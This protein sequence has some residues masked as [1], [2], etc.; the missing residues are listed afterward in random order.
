MIPKRRIFAAL[1]RRFGS[2]GSVARFL[3]LSENSVERKVNSGQG[4]D[5]EREILPMEDDLAVFP[6]TVERFRSALQQMNNDPRLS[7]HVETIHGALMSI[8]GIAPEHFA[9]PR[10]DDDGG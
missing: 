7:G 6:Y 1:R 8:K 10:Q 9:P 3:D 5:V 4:I 2:Y